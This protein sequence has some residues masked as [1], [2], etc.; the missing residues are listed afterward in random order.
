MMSAHKRTTVTVSEEQYR[1]LHEAAMKKRFLEKEI[2]TIR[3]Q[4]KKETQDALE[5]A[6]NGVEKRQQAYREM[7][8]E[9]KK[10]Q[11]M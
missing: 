1:K 11:R 6:V 2:P 7:M 9:M 5:S 4:L 10:V 8:D 3:R